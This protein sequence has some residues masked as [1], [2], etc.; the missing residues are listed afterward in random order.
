MP[1]NFAFFRVSSI[2]KPS[3]KYWKKLK[4]AK[5][6]IFWFCSEMLAANSAHCTAIGLKMNPLLN[7][8]EPVLPKW[9]SICLISFLSEWFGICILGWVIIVTIFSFR[10]NSGGKCFSQIHTKHLTVTIDAFTIHNSLWQG[11]KVNMPSKKD[12]ALVI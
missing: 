9:T 2:V 3:K 4:K 8:M 5:R 10:Y 7:Y 11:K 12:M 6:N 1:S